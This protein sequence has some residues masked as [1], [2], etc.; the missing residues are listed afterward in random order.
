MSEA[1]EF[2]VVVY[3]ASGYT[4]RLVAEYMAKQY[5]A[6]SGVT[7]AM[8]G[9]N[10]EKLA[11][12]SDEI[13]APADTPLVTADASDP[14]SL[15][16]MVTNAKSIATTVGPY[17]LYGEALV[18]SC[19]QH[20]T[21]YV[22]LC[23]E[24]NWMAEMIGKYS[25]AAK[26]SGARI[27]FSC[28]FDSIPFDLGVFFL[29]EEAKKTLGGPVPR[30]R[31]RVRAMEGKFS[32]GTA[33]SMKATMGA[34]MK[35]PGLIALLRNPFALA[36]GFEGPAQPDDSAPF[37]DD[38]IGMW[39]APFVMATINTKNVHRSNQLLGHAYGTDFQYDEMMVTGP[40]EQGEQMAKAVASMD[41]MGGETPAPGEGPTKEERESGHYNVLF[42]GTAADG[43]TIK[44]GVT[45][46]KDPGYGSTSKML[47]ESAV[48][49]VQ[50]ATDTPGG[51]YTTAPA[52]GMKLIER[53]RANAGL[54]FDVE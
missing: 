4:G 27:V 11:Q 39:V 44:V 10:A 53:L 31:G 43:Q 9:R 5:P 38:A 15:E 28:G 13:G 20:G 34:A 50:D 45:G 17:Q 25:D 33:A 35:D 36:E 2:D 47:A 30:V 41:P 40:G 3:G 7:W 21:D 51:I 46:D 8:A 19:A 12:V 49:L 32:G 54:T 1:R 52:M 18:A 14:A 26:A 6:G 37:E 24:P 16:A 42:L 23:G 22:D 29:Q 48:C